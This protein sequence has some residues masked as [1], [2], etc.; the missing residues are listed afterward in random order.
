MIVTVTPNPALD[1]TYTVPEVRLG[2]SQ[3]VADVAEQAGG[4]GINVARVLASAGVGAEAVAPLGGASGDVF[5]DDLAAAGVPFTAVPVA[6]PLR[7]TLSIVTPAETTNLNETGGPL[8]PFETAALVAAVDARLVAARAAGPD[9]PIVLV[10]AGSFPPGTPTSLVG[11]LVDAGRR[12]GAVVIVDTSKA[13]L[14]AA[15]DAGADLV[16]PN[17]HEIEAV[18]GLP[19]PLAGAR[20]L[21]RRSGGIVLASLGARGL[22]AVRADGPIVAVAPGAPVAG[23]TTGAGDA[24]V[25]AIAAVIDAAP[26]SDPFLPFD[27]ER[28]ETTLRTAATWAA[29]AVLAP[30]AGALADTTDLAERLRLQTTTENP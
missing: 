29:A 2:A 8:A 30:V 24:V 10:V 1:V 20:A 22:A 17:E 12:V 15:V 5:R 3:R 6:T 4:K 7:R 9:Q 26:S 13:Y 25:A 21:A 16:K 14:D 23:N 28:I 27:A 18:T 11:H 19:D